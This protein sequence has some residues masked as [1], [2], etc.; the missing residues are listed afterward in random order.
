MLKSCSY[1]GRIHDSKNWCKQKRDAEQRRWNNR[2]STRALSFRR[3]NAWRDKSTEVRKRQHY[4]CVCCA[5]NLEGTIE[6]LNTEGLSV[7]HITPIEEDY[8]LRLDDENLITVCEVHH[9]MC[10]AGKIGRDVQRKLAKEY[11]EDMP[12]LIL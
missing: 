7:H 3:T 5:H 2:K 1:C 4:M 6:T 12:T 10:E 11:L 9:E 8:D